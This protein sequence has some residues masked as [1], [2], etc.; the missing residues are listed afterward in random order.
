MM[1]AVARLLLVASFTLFLGLPARAVS[2]PE[3]D[4]DYYTGCNGTLTWVGHSHKNC[5]LGGFTHTGTPAGDWSI[6]ETYDCDTGQYNTVYH[7]WVNGVAYVV[8]EATFYA[9]TC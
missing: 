1:K 6:T 4:I 8:S 7:H 3:T 9:A 5:G 2:G